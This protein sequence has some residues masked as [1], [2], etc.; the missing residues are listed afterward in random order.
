MLTDGL[1]YGLVMIVIQMRLTK[2]A[3]V[4]TRDIKAIETAIDT[5][6]IK[7]GTPEAIFF[8]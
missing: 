1:G 2:I 7:F 8:S 3:T 5:L 4:N 6:V